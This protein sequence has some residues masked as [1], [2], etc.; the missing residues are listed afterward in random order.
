MMPYK[1][2]YRRVIYIDPTDTI[3]AKMEKWHFPYSVINKIGITE[4]TIWSDKL[5]LHFSGSTPEMALEKYQEAV[6]NAQKTY[7]IIRHFFNN[8]SGDKPPIVILEGL[9]LQEAKSHCQDPETCSK[10]CTDPLRRLITE[11][12]GPW[13]DAFEEE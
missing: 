2:F 11:V 8:L 10:T 12:D 13:F 6:D 4:W 7:K 1:E 3:A 9:T 5:H